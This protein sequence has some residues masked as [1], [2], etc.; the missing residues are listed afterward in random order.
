M[1]KIIQS[2]V[3]LRANGKHEL[4]DLKFFLNH[5]DLLQRV[6]KRQLA[7]AIYKSFN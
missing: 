4:V 2:G 5:C 7:I 6:L 3:T 1:S